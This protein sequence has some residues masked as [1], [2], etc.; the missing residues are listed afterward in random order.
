MESIMGGSRNL[1]REGNV[2][3]PGQ[4][5][6]SMTALF[7]CVAVTVLPGVNIISAAV[8]MLPAHTIHQLFVNCALQLLYT[9]D[10][11]AP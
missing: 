9:S 7:C 11:L 1:H 4:S 5:L 3:T 10:C 6:M 2:V 8:T